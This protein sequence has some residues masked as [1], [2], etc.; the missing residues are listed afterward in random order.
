M[1]TF[2]KKR[3]IVNVEDLKYIIENKIRDFVVDLNNVN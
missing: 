1:F 3:K 2:K